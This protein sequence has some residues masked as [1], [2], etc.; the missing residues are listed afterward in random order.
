[1]K[2]NGEPRKPQAPASLAN[3]RPAQPGEIR[4]PD[5]KNGV[6]PYTNALRALAAELLPEHLRQALNLRFRSQLFRALK[7]D[8]PELELKQI[9]DL[10]KRGCTWAQANSVRLHVA[11]V[12]EGDIGAAVEIRESVEGHDTRGV[13]LPER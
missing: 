7:D 11:A 2:K 13:R 9:P 12:L 6:R 10:Y 5:G 3:L 8:T 4:N 1:M